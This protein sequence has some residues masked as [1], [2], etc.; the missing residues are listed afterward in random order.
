VSAEGR[1]V[2]EEL[3]RFV[4]EGDLE[5]G[6]RETLLALVNAAIATGDPDAAW[7][8]TRL[9][10]LTGSALVVHPASRRILLRWHARQQRWLQVGGHADPGERSALAVALREAREETGL[11]DLEV[12][13]SGLVHVVIVNVPA[14]KGEPAHEH[15]DLRYVLATASPELAVAEDSVARVRWLSVEDALAEVGND[16]VAVLIERAGRMF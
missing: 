7:S 1:D 4:P 5:S 15:G 12:V 10:H 11:S 6:D 14:G 8:R 13:G 9:L 3:T 16:N 2:R